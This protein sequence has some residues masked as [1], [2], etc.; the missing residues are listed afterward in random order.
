M[1]PTSSNTEEEGDL[2]LQN[3]NFNRQTKKGDCAMTVLGEVL[4][5]T[6][7][8]VMGCKGVTDPISTGGKISKNIKKSVFPY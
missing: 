5:H 7:K 3:S 6:V 1:H 8:V 2:K 4:V